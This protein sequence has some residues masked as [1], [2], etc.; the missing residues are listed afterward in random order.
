[1]LS[2][3]INTDMSSPEYGHVTSPENGNMKEVMAVDTG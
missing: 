3:E 1:M 2:L